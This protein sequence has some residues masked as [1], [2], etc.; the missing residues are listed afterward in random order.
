M[1]TENAVRKN[2]IFEVQPDQKKEVENPESTILQT[3]QLILDQGFCYWCCGL[4]GGDVIKI[5]L[6]DSI[7]SINYPVWTVDEIE[8]S[9]DLPISTLKLIQ[10]LKKIKTG[11]RII[12]VEDI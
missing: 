12:S 11:A 3:E 4:F 1:T 5:V 9:E 6:D 10:H 2:R 7:K 8:K